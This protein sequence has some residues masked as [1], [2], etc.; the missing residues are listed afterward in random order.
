MRRASSCFSPRVIRDVRPVGGKPARIEGGIREFFE[1]ALKDGV[2]IEQARVELD[3][4][5]RQLEAQY[6][7]SN[8]SVRALINLAQ[9]QV[10]QN[11]RPAL[12]MLLGAVT[13][14]LLIACANVA[15][16]LLA[17]AVGRQKEMA[18]RLAIAPAARGSSGNW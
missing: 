12:L 13:L 5:A 3:T 9:D 4:I 15:N 2:T 8:K 6:P 16:L 18:V 11:V 1:R 17:R 14:V 7:E 10:V